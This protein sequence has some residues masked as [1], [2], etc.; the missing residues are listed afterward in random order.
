MPAKTRLDVALVA[1]GLAPTRE[2]AQSL[3]SS[4]LVTVNGQP[5]RRAADAVLE[6][7]E[8]AAG[9]DRLPYVSR[10]GLKLEA[11][12]A[13]WPIDPTGRVCIDLGASTGG[14]TDLLLQRGASRVYAVDV[15]YGQLHYKLRGDPRVVVMERTNARDLTSL[16]EPPSLLVADVSFIS[17]RLVLPP[18]W[19][20]LAA[21]ADAITLIKPQ[22][23]AGRGQVGK[24]GVVRDTR[25]RRQVLLG[26]LEWSRSQPWRL[27]DLGVSPIR[28][29]AG[30]VEFLGLWRQGAEAGSDGLADIALRTDQGGGDE[31]SV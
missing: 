20:L 10:G 6:S 4:G 7:D 1:R 8:V 24:G 25:V 22:F 26:A 14:F 31:G 13:Q 11:A 28:G 16:P 18:A 19:P 29:P 21:D 23:E 9:D 15:G 2:R 30:N 27:V 17:L 12:L 5:A 3:I